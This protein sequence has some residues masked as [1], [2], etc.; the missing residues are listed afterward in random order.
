[1]P[2][3]IVNGDTEDRSLFL[4]KC[5]IAV[6]SPLNWAPL[7]LSQS[8]ALSMIVWIS[9]RFASAEGPVNPGRVVVDERDRSSVCID[10]V[11]YKVRVEEE[12]QYRRE[13]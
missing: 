1:M 7:R 13:R 10:F 5:K 4:V 8:S 6:L 9:A 11:L 2:P 3:L 12:E